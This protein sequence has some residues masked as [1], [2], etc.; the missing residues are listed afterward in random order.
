MNSFIV[1]MLMMV[2]VGTLSL[3]KARAQQRWL[4]LAA[5][6]AVSVPAIKGS[7]W[8][9]DARLLPH[10]GLT[11]FVS[12]NDYL[13]LKSGLLY[14]M[15]GMETNADYKPDSIYTRQSFTS[16]NDY[17]LLNVPLQL[18][19]TFGKHSRDKYRIAAGMSYGFMLKATSKI[20]V[21]SFFEDG[22]YE[23]QQYS[24]THVVTVDEKEPSTWAPK[25]EGA[26]VAVFTPAVR[27]DFTYQFEEKLLL[28]VFYEYHLQD[29]RTRVVRGTSGRLHYA[30]IAVG[31]RIW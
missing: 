5:G 27:T 30:G 24:Y 23:Q 17:H 18:A 8:K 15:K 13:S 7:D 1:S 21:N 29:H 3:H 20:A 6:G 10:V 31:V 28:T 9:H 4:E 16:R 11:G 12:F 2:F 14:Q 25:E 19:F 22:T 26:P